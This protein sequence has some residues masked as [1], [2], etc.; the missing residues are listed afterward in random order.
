[1]DS[2]INSICGSQP[3]QEKPQNKQLE[4]FDPTIQ[5]ACFGFDHQT[6]LNLGMPNDGMSLPISNNVQTCNCAEVSP[7]MHVVS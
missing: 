6:K 7:I 4:Q 1:M 2:N 3:S 5:F